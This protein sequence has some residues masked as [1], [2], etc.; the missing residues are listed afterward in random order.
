MAVALLTGRG[1]PSLTALLGTGPVLRE[2]DVAL[3]G[4]RDLD[5]LEREALRASGIHVF[6]MHDIDRRGLAAVTEEA[7][8]SWERIT[9]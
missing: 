1:H 9:V 3:V 5:T 8:I 4:T 7:M 6:T 2:Q